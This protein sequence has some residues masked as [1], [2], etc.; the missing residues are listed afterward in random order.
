MKFAIVGIGHIGK[1]HVAVL[2]AEPNAEI[3]AICDVVGEKA[4]EQSELYNNIPYYTD[5]EEMLEKSGCEIVSIATPHGLHA[6]MA[7]LAAKHKKHILVEKPMALSVDDSNRMIET[8]KEEGVK[9]YVIK[10]NRFNVPIKLTTEALDEKRLGKI[11]M[12]Q[13]N[14]MWNRHAGYYNDS[15]WKGKLDLEGGALHTQ[16]SHFL[17]LMIWWFGELNN[18]KTIRGTL[19]HNIEF[20]DCGVSALQFESGVIGSLLWS[21]AVYNKNYEG[22]ITIL[23]EKGTIKIGGKYLNK[24]EFWDVQS[25]PLP[26]DIEFSDKPNSYGKYKGSSSNHDKLIHELM[27]NFAESRKGIVEG[28]EGVLTIKA[29]EEIYNGG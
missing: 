11:Y 24:I 13:C 7:V 20:E 19:H 3:V 26:D 9:L 18:A 27:E 29:I 4:K 17:D 22:S 15:D 21:T 14:V 23:G 2:D 25:Y 6:D 12:V 1:R 10:Q 28:E 16:A 5:Y 8:A